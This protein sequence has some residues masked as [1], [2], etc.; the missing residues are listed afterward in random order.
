M[1]ITDLP[2]K[3][4]SGSKNASELAR[5]YT[6]INAR[7]IADH[8]QEHYGTRGYKIK[9]PSESEMRGLL[10]EQKAH[11]NAYIATKARIEMEEYN[12]LK[13]KRKVCD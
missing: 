13:D 1:E 8:I 9:Y 5:E 3:T 12:L 7:G 6:S 4:P 2:T 11:L 10:N